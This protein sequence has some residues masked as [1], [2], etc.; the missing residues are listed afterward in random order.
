MSLVFSEEAY[1]ARYPDVA[2]AVQAGV[3]SSGR[4]HWLQYGVSEGR[5]GA[6][7]TMVDSTWYL[8]TYPDVA[9]A[10]MN[11]ET[12]FLTYGRYENRNPNA[13][14]DLGLYKQFNS[15]SIRSG[16]S[17]Y[18]HFIAFGQTDNRALGINYSE[19]YYLA[20]NSDV[21]AAVRNG[22][23]MSGWDHYVQYGHSENRT[24][25]QG[26]VYDNTNL[27]KLLFGTTGNDTLR[28]ASGGADNL[29][30]REGSDTL[31]GGYGSNT[32]TGG[33]GV[34]LFVLEAGGGTTTT[35]S[36]ITITDFQQGTDRI[37]LPTLSGSIDSVLATA[38]DVGTSTIL[39]YYP[40]S[41]GTGS[42]TVTLTGYSGSQLHSS[43]FILAS[44]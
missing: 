12:H 31:Y 20:N 30:G 39:T 36:A 10:G 28:P 41:S 37:Q 43:D 9:A 22:T 42:G 25:S 6:P 40:G 29:L 3:L 19:D 33:A 7:R 13:Y 44:A 8:A 18:D 2:A 4:Q 14:I 16:T 15:D 21:A 32:L 17:V 24:F 38:R 23:F 27:R 34:D 11:A 26:W 5:I 35:F 1:L